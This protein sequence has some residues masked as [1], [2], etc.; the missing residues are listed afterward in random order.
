MDVKSSALMSQIK[1][2]EQT[3]VRI[4][5]QFERKKNNKYHST[6][7]SLSFNLAKKKTMLNELADRSKGRAIF[8]CKD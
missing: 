7:I 5:L 1:H 4:E 6:L 3:N 2:L 8:K